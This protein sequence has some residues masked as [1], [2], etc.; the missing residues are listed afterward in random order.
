[1]LLSYLK[2]CFI[3]ETISQCEKIVQISQIN[4]IFISE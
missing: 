2:G 3:Q 1:M 4:L